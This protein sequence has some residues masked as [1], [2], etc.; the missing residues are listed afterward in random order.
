MSP[1][2]V[3][4]R[5]LEAVAPAHCPVPRLANAGVAGDAL[6]AAIAELA[7]LGFRPEADP[8]AGLRLGA[9]PD[10]LVPDEI[11]AV[12]GTGGGSFRVRVFRSTESTND[13]AARAAAAGG[14]AGLAVFAEAQTAGRGRRGRAWESRAGLG[15]WFSVLA[16][17]GD[18]A[19]PGRLSAAATVAVAVAVREAAGLGTEVKWPNDVLVGGRKLAGILIE[20]GRDRSGVP[21]AVVGIGL[22]VNHE[23]GDFGEKAAGR[24]TSVRIETGRLVRRAGLAGAILAGLA[25]RLAEPF[26]EVRREWMAWC[27]TQGRIVRV[28]GDPKVEGFVEGLDDDGSLLVRTAGGVLRRV[29]AGEVLV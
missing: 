6:R 20:T 4:F 16:R 2:A 5:E 11:E 15:L 1:L 22:N 18:V 12:A 25:R 23:P 24:A 14:A 28:T 7:H 10:V 17:P 13:L 29:A 19:Q 26:E 3:V 21:F 8:V 9:R 27:G